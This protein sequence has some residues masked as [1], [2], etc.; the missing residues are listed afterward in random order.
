MLGGLTLHGLFVAL[1]DASGAVQEESPGK[2][3]LY[4][5]AGGSSGQTSKD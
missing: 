1:I 4:S 5:P 2:Q 3:Q